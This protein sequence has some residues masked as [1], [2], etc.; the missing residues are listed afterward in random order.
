MQL[1]Y[2]NLLPSTA[3]LTYMGNRMVRRGADMGGQV[4]LDSRSRGAAVEEVRNGGS[5]AQGIGGATSTLISASRVWI[6]QAL[7]RPSCC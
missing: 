1:P 6:V 4:A 2:L 5:R 7:R 3:L